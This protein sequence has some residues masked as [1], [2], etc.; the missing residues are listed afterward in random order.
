MSAVVAGLDRECRLLALRRRLAL[1][2]DAANL[3]GFV[4]AAVAA[5]AVA[6]AGRFWWLVHGF[7][8]GPHWSGARRG[9]PNPVRRGAQAWRLPMRSI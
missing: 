1:V 3:F 4:D 5:Q 6:Y 7:S 9:R 8:S 2:A